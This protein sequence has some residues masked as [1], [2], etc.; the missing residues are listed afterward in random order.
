LDECNIA[1]AAIGNADTNATTTSDNPRPEGCYD[2]GN[3]WLATHTR[4]IGTGVDGSRFPICRAAGCFCDCTG[5]GF[6]GANCERECGGKLFDDGKVDIVGG[7]PADASCEWRLSCSNPARI[8]QLAFTAF[9]TEAGKDFVDIY[10]T[11]DDDGAV[12]GSPSH[13]L[14][15]PVI[16]GHIWAGGASMAVRLRS[17]EKTQGTGF[18]ADFTCVDKCDR[19][20][21]KLPK[22]C[23]CA[24]GKFFAVSTAEPATT[25]TPENTLRLLDCRSVRTAQLAGSRRSV[26]PR[27]PIAPLACTVGLLQ[28]LRAASAGWISFLTS[29]ASC[30]NRQSCPQH[31]T[32]SAQ[33]DGCICKSGFYDAWQGSGN[34][35]GN[36]ALEILLGVLLGYRSKKGKS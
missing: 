6:A 31:Q 19:P 8:P 21:E 15:G 34:T 28:Q 23:A 25:A 12:F 18:S 33:G 27:V 29:P 32:T 30:V 35:T 7:Y 22:K 13:E 1:A 16:P 4:N 24:P 20:A 10:H 17:D 2:D 26:P 9:N 14:S 36:I 11:F 5:T 3:L